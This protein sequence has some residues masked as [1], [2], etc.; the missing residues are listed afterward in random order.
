MNY[1]D[2]LNIRLGLWWTPRERY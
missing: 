2:S 1:N